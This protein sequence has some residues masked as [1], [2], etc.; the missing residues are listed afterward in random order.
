MK[1]YE[2]DKEK[3]EKLKNER[4]IGFEEIVLK[5]IAGEV[6]DIISNPSSNFSSQKVYVIQIYNYIY[7]VP[8]VDDGERVFLKTIIPSRKATKKYLKK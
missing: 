4:G 6:L 7:Y 2:W 5:I 1:I 8:H 3:G